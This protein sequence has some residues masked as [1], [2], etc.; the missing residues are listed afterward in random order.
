MPAHLTRREMDVLRLVTN[1]FS[2]AH[3]AEKLVLSPRTVNAYLTSIYAKL[4]V[5]SRHAA[6]RVARDRHLI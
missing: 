2:N 3:I 4:D 5:T 6:A 1:G